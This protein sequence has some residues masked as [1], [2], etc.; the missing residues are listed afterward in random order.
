MRNSAHFRRL[1]AIT[2]ELRVMFGCH[3]DAKVEH[4]TMRNA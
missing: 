3:S 1:L 4:E 2:H